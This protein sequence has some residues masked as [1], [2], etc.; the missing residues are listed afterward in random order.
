MSRN[1]KTHI[2]TSLCFGIYNISLTGFPNVTSKLMSPQKNFGIKLVKK[3]NMHTFATT[4]SWSER[5]FLCLYTT[6]FERS[7]APE[8]EQTTFQGDSVWCSPEALVKWDVIR[9]SPLYWSVPMTILNII[10][11][12]NYNCCMQV[13]TGIYRGFRH[14]CA[15][16]KR[17]SRTLSLKYGYGS[18][19]V[20]MV[21]SSQ[22]HLSQVNAKML[23][24]CVSRQQFLYE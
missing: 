14:W 11:Q 16:L 23:G 7:W 21:L 19:E 1:K 15:L 12:N 22:Q 3:C 4:K 10:K 5:G 9:S 18:P 24:W 17:H 20:T 13:S 8:S 6:I 2:A